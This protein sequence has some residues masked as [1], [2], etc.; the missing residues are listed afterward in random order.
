M[1]KDTAHRVSRRIVEFAPRHGATVIVFKHLGRFRPERGRYSR[2][3]NSKRAYWLRGRIFRYTCYKAWEEKI[4]TCRVNPCDTSRKCAV[5]G[6]PLARYGEGEPAVEYRPGAP[7]VC[8][9]NP[10]R[11]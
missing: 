1:D 9:L 5:C 3:A 7:L 6:S 2:R 10:E 8:C 4:V 11:Q